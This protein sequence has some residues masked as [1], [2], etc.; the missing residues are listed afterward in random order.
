MD[1]IQ[2]CRKTKKIFKYNR[3][4]FDIYIIPF[5]VAQSLRNKFTITFL[6]PR[7]DVYLENIAQRN[8]AIEFINQLATDE[9]FLFKKH[10]N[11]FLIKDVQG[12]CQQYL[13][14]SPIE[15]IEISNY[16]QVRPV[17][18]EIDFIY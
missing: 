4:Y 11:R 3:K 8:D 2:L 18:M 16:K 5:L 14:E 12:I 15:W 7:W 6:L 1:Q 10:S 9:I 13:E 17:T